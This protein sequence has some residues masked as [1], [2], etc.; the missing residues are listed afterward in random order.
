VGSFD[1]IN[2]E[3][4]NATLIS[5]T[6]SVMRELLRRKAV[7]ASVRA[8]MLAG[9]PVPPGL[10]RK[11]Y[12]NCDVKRVLNLYGHSEI[13]LASTIAELQPGNEDKKVSIGRPVENAQAFVLDA[14]MELVPGGIVDELYLSAATSARGYFNRPDLTAERAWCRTSLAPEENVMF[15]INTWIVAAKFSG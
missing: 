2:F 11:L 14:H 9:E 1:G 12:D 7:P 5:V 8:I 13:S 4:G 15:S 6:P 10:V 3:E